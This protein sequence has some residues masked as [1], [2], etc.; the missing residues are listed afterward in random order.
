MQPADI[1]ILPNVA[2]VT[3]WRHGAL[4]GG[5]WKTLALAILAEPAMQRMHKGVVA[6]C[7]RIAMLDTDP[8]DVEQRKL[9]S[10]S[11]WIDDIGGEIV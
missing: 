5:D 6:D 11:D 3:S 1:A 9:L 7:Y 8:T 10:L 4:D 2:T